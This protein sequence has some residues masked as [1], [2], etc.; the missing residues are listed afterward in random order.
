MT[1][2]DNDFVKSLVPLDGGDGVGDSFSLGGVLTV[3]HSE[4]WFDLVMRACDQQKS[5]HYI[6]F[7][8]SIKYMLR[9][10]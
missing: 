9:K 6:L 8:H 2:H 10:L 3:S 5:D 7:V 1:D 4:F